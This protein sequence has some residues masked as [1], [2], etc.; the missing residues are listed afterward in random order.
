MPGSPIPQQERQGSRALKNFNNLV[1]QSRCGAI[2]VGGSFLFDHSE[3]WGLW[4]CTAGHCRS[5]MCSFIGVWSRPK[6]LRGWLAKG[7]KNWKS[8]VVWSRYV[9]VPVKMVYRISFAVV[10][11]LRKLPMIRPGFHFVQSSHG[12]LGASCLFCS[13]AFPYCFHCIMLCATQLHSSHPQAQTSEHA[14]S[15]VK[16]SV[17][18]HFRISL[19][20]CLVTCNR[21]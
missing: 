2:V 13:D 8:C 21:L 1:R 19:H 17:S 5:K 4:S 12:I 14:G 10:R 11:W 6:E 20:L 7:S 18:V 9:H 15:C 3:T 16:E